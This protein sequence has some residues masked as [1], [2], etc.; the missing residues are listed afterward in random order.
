MA[1]RLLKQ[2]VCAGHTNRL[3][4]GVKL[5]YHAAVAAMKLTHLHVPKPQREFACA[6]CKFW[7]MNSLYWN[8]DV[9]LQYLSCLNDLT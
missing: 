7:R 6:L 5:V 1:L 3:Q 4:A 9:L 8:V 2:R